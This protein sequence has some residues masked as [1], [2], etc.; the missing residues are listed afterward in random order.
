ML[1][2]NL[3]MSGQDINDFLKR[4]ETD[5]LLGSD[6]TWS[7]ISP[8]PAAKIAVYALTRNK[9][10]FVSH[11]VDVNRKKDNFDLWEFL[12]SCSVQEAPLELLL[13][14]L[15]MLPAQTDDVYNKSGFLFE[16]L[17]NG[18]ERD[19]EILG[20]EYDVNAIISWDIDLSTIL[21]AGKKNKSKLYGFYSK[22]KKLIS[23]QPLVAEQLL[24]LLVRSEDEDSKKDLKFF[25]PNTDIFIF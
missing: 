1:P 5:N 3:S 20:T 7:G 6:F 24:Q 16:Y 13:P 22:L 19:I 2:Y 23:L 9:L 4:I 15:D 12:Y 8:K 10:D 18:S 14:Y 21:K 11:W 25:F 17:A